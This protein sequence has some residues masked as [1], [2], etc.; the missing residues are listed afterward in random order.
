MKKIFGMMAFGIAVSASMTAQAGMKNIPARVTSSF[1]HRYPDARNVEWK[2]RI[3]N[4]TVHFNSKGMNYMAKFDRHG[5]WMRSEKMMTKNELPI[6]V[7]EGIR[8]T[9][10]ERWEIKSSYEQFEPNQHP[11]YHVKAAKGDFRRREL[12]F[13]QRGHLVK[14]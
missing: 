8:K 10:Y 12:V 6:A 4:Y 11:Q 14:S 7:K 1:E 13:N 3:T 5:A 9:G 2:D